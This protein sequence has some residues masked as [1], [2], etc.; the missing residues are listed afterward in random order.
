MINNISIFRRS[1]SILKVTLPPKYEHVFMCRMTPIQKD[2]MLA[3]IGAV[4]QDPTMISPTGKVNPIYLFSVCCKIWNHPDVIYDLVQEGKSFDDL[5]IELP[6]NKQ[7]K[8]TND[9]KKKMNDK[10]K[11]NGRANEI[12]NDF[13]NLTTG[14]TSS[15]PSYPIQFLGSSSFMS[16]TKSQSQIDYSWA[17]PILENYQPGVIDNS[18][19]TVLM[20]EIIDQSIPL[21]DRLLIFSQSLFTLDLIEKM[22]SQRYVPGTNEKWSKLVNYYRLDGSTSSLDREKFIRSF[23]NNEEAKL[24]LLS[25]RAGSL[26]VNL[27]GAN[28]IIVMDASWNPCHD[29]QAACRI[30]RYGQVR[31][32]KSLIVLTINN[33]I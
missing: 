28:R 3:F 13:S 6:N 22:L 14:L 20:F 18:I 5:D 7:K 10:K 23:N 8:L 1:H 16:N 30:Y 17:K 31:T 9:K 27:I 4:I 25:T 32:E 29:A 24:F 11:A 26:G 2:L 12:I 21:G 19:K 33:L 15:Y